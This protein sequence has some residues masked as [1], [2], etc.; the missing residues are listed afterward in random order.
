MF[1]CLRTYYFSRS[2]IHPGNDVLPAPFANGEHPA[3]PLSSRHVQSKKRGCS[4]SS[5]AALAALAQS[6]RMPLHPP[7]AAALAR[8]A[9]MQHPL[10][11][12]ARC[13]HMQ[14]PLAAALARHTRM[15]QHSVA[16]P[17]SRCSSRSLHPNAALPRTLAAP[18]QRCSILTYDIVS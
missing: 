17:A 3:L 13:T 12:H 7:A 14:H 18:D 15:Q 4:T 16:A 10:A 5:L 2:C 1:G 8:S 9:R 11:P 6:T